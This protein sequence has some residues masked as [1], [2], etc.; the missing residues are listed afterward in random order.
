MFRALIA[1][2]VVALAASSATAQSGGDFQTAYQIALSQ[3]GT[4]ARLI[5]ARTEG[6]TTFGFYFAKNRRVIEIEIVGTAKAFKVGKVA[7]SD[8]GGV[9]PDV[10]RLIAKYAADKVKLPEGRLLEIAQENLKDTPLTEVGLEAEGDSLV[11]VAGSV[12]LD[13]ATGKTLP[14]K[15]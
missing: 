13:S 1:S 4:G 2:V 14:G 6:P 5:K 8:T 3:V 7:S 15:K 10:L 12:R 11:F 9:S